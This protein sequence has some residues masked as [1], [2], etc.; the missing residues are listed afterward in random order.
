M[1]TQ[2]WRRL[3]KKG[4]DEGVT[5]KRSRKAVRVTRAIVG[6]SVEEVRIIFVAF[7]YNAVTA[8]IWDVYVIYSDLL[9]ISVN[10]IIHS[11][12]KHHVAPQEE[13]C[14]QAKGCCHGGIS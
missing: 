1:W 4:K 7:L 14:Q 9:I 3:N 10:L 12:I 6:A 13:T 11:S 5:K 8:I 2:S